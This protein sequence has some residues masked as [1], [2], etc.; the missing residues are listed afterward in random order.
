MEELRK[1][2][3]TELVWF[4]PVMEK[5][6]E[7]KKAEEKKEPVRMY[8]ACNYMPRH[9]PYMDAYNPYMDRD[10]Q[11]VGSDLK[12]ADEKKDPVA[13]LLKA[14]EEYTKQYVVKSGGD[15]TK[16]TEFDDPFGDVQS[17]RDDTEIWNLFA[18]EYNSSNWMESPEFTCTV[19]ASLLGE[20]DLSH[21]NVKSLPDE[22][23]PAMKA[24]KKLVLKSCKLFMELPP[25]VGQL[26]NLEMLDLDETEIFDLPLEIRSLWKLKFL[27]VLFYG[28]KNCGKKLRQNALI[29]PGT[30]WSLTGLTDL[31][32]DV[33]PD[34]ERWDAVVG[35]VIEE[36]CSL[37][38]LKSLALYVPNAEFLDKRRA[39][40]TTLSLLSL[41]LLHKFRFTIG[42]H[43]QRIISRVPKKVEARFQEWDKCFKFVKGKD[44]P[45]E[46]KSV[47]ERATSFY[48]DRHATATSLSDFGIV[49][50]RLLQFCLL[51]ECNQ[52]ETI[53]DGSGEES[54][55]L[56]PLIYR[57]EYL[58]VY[59]LK[60]L[61]SIW[62]N[63]LPEYSLSALKL[64]ALHQC[65][66][67]S[68]IFSPSL[69]AS[70]NLLE[71]IVIEDCAQVTSVVSLSSDA[72]SS[73]FSSSM[74]LP[75]LKAVLLLYLPNLITISSGVHI[76][77][78]LERIGF[79]NCPK[80]ENLSTKEMSSSSLRVI[81]GEKKWWEALKWNEMDW[82]SNKVDHLKSV[83]S[84]IQRERG[85]MSQ[86]EEVVG[87]YQ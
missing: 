20:L 4:G 3:L 71:F 59:R 51:E 18:Q 56:Q 70:L 81:K 75:N 17:F 10:R 67:L 14:Y 49:N 38:T 68:V 79:Y 12:K 85:V 58:H 30:I 36:A 66:K 84:P 43:K 35:Y 80:L 11:Y 69:L 21:T 42:Q 48:L 86:M 24:L 22:S 62:R 34:D 57:L 7:S 72:T 60:N 33:N 54:S 27:R 40:G 31:S 47:L 82:E 46:I 52:V 55:K 78:Q 19:K 64:L 13:H 50:L 5:K 32:I 53:I 74:H 23:F 29:H 2:C 63:Q 28:Y 61:A 8:Y 37:G 65:P 87:E 9:P 1:V 15:F 41:C 73:N 16:P 76:A 25:Q 83:F 6:E 39:D 77:A 45:G 44:I 26:E